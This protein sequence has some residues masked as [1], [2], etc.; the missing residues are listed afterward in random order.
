[1]SFCLYSCRINKPARCYRPTARCALLSYRFSNGS[2]FTSR[3]SNVVIFSVAFDCLCLSVCSVCILS[4]YLGQV[5]VSRSSGQG[6]GH[7]SKTRDCSGFH[8]RM[9]SRGLSAIT[10]LLVRVQ[11]CLLGI[12]TIYVLLTSSCTRM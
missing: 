2:N 9:R 10:E 7:S 12:H 1:M 11:E 4:E 8:F 3:E 6:Q 5:R